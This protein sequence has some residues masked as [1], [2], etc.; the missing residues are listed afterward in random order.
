MYSP[1]SKEGRLAWLIRK[2]STLADTR[3][4]CNHCNKLFERNE[5]ISHQAEVNG[6]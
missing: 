6:F 2:Y 5:F 4:R 1:Q 3:I